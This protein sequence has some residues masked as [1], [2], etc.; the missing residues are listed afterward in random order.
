MDI[1]EFCFHVLVVVGIVLRWAI[2][3]HVSYYSFVW[4]Y[5]QEWDGWIYGNYNFYFLGTTIL[6]SIALHQFTF[7][8][9]SAVGFLEFS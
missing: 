1:G 4:I 7:S 8:P 2:E 9:N 5:I 3:I 6:S